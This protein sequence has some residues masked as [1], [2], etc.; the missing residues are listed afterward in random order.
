VIVDPY[1]P[2]I[3]DKV[4][5]KRSLIVVVAFITSFI[6]A[7]FLVFLIEFIRGEN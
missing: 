2:D 4:G 6:L 3:K 5:P 1:V 7:I